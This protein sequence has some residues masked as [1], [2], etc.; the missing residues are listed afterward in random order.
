MEWF[1]P[2]FDQIFSR[3]QLQMRKAAWLCTLALALAVPAMAQDE[4]PK[5]EATAG[6]SYVRVN[7]KATPTGGSEVSQGFN[8]NGGSSSVAFNLNRRLGVVVY[9]GGYH[10]SQSVTFSGL[11][12]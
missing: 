3:R 10:T 5:A 11:G 7:A 4:T 1:S 6:Y 12:T 9:F 2:S 8:F